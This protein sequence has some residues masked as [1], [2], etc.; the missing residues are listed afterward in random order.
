MPCLLR[1]QAK[2]SSLD[3]RMN[4]LS[5]ISVKILGYLEYFNDPGKTR[6]IVVRSTFQQRR[7]LERSSLEHRSFSMSPK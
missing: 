2:R 1:D 3:G 5:S 7:F 4:E 6:D